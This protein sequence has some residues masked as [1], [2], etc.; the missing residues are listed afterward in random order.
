MANVAVVLREEI[1]RLARKQLKSETE[2]LKK[3]SSRYRAEIAAMKRRIDT[4]EKQLARLSKEQPNAVAADA[5]E[6]G[7]SAKMRF[8]R[9]GFISMR[10]RLGLSAEK[11]GALLGVSGQTVHKWESGTRP[12][13]EQLAAISAVRKMGKREIAARLNEIT[14]GTH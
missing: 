2:S 5:K 4:L 10:K 14:S 1:N 8:R 13:R 6:N 12:R 3:A 9:D 7:D 11:M